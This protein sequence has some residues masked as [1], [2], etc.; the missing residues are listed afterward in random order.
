LELFQA[1]RQWATR[2]ADQRFPTLQALYDATKAYAATA[3]EKTVPFSDL[4]VEKR[5]DDVQL[6]GKADIP[7]TLTN[8]SFG[9][10]CARV[11]APASYLRD[12][13]ATLAAQNLNYGLSQHKD[14]GAKVDLLFHK[15]GGLLLR[16]ITSDIYER[17]WNWEIAERLLK[18]QSFGWEP[19]RP[20]F[21][22]SEADFPALYAS[23][24]DMFAFVRL[25]RMYIQQPVNKSDA[26]LYR[27][28]IYANSEVGAA[29]IRV[30]KFWY[31]GMCGNH[32][33]WGASDVVEVSARH[34]GKVR[35]KLRMFD[36]AIRKFADDSVSDDEA[37]IKKAANVRIAQTKD[38]LLDRLFGIRNLGLSR[39]TLE[40]G[41]SS[42][43]PEQDG[44]PLTVWG[45]T[46]GLT[47]YSQQTPYA[48]E[49]L[50]VDRAAGKLLD[51]EF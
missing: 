18:L 4:R 9:Q 51:I 15:N 7:A 46:Q 16:A 40:A 50:I 39:K 30:L 47:R 31:S 37:K 32:I 22:K 43:K 34:V 23:D 49:R 13:P 42:V 24:H 3:G 17:I 29:K 33:I 44:D 36:I 6:V 8:W 45:M 41:Y 27:G 10:L 19:A 28:A 48:D 14:D 26:P 21:N 2:P 38:E 5:D 20:D 11:G 12:L 1:H 35:D 25:P